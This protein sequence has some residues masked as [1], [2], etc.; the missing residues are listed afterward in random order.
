MDHFFKQREFQQRFTAK[1]PDID[2][3]GSR[4][5][6]ESEADDVIRN[7]QRHPIRCF[8]DIAVVAG[9]VAALGQ[10]QCVFHETPIKSEIRQVISWVDDSI[11]A[12]Q[13]W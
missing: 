4:R 13:E 7:A 12:T 5:V 2:I 10:K 8:A 6:P 1:K 9:Q 11:A 3:L